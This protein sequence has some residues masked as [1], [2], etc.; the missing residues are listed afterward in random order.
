MEAAYFSEA[1][2]WEPY[3]FL[4]ETRYFGEAAVRGAARDFPVGPICGSRVFR[5]ETHSEWEP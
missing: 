5:S 4:V 2:D 1:R 3:V